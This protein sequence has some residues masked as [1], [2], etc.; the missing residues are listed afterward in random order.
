MKFVKIRA[1]IGYL[2]LDKYGKISKRPIALAKLKNVS[3]KLPG[4][5]FN[6]GATDALKFVAELTEIHA[7]Y[8]LISL[9][10]FDGRFRRQLIGS[11]GIAPG[12]CKTET[13]SL[14]E[15]LRNRH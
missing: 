11:V 9:R 13:L 7:V 8:D 14:S 2:I 6:Q 10:S 1:K 15:T 5:R 3:S 4:G 12:G